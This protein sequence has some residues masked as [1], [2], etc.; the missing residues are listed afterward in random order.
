MTDHQ[1]AAETAEVSGARPDSA[2]THETAAQPVS[3]QTVEAVVRAQLS[4]ALGGKRGM[5]EA[6][7][8]TLTFTVAYMASQELRLSLV[9]SVGVAVVLAVIRLIQRTS[10]QFVVNSLFGIGIAAVFALRSGDAE[11]FALPGII[12]NA[13]YAAVLTLTVLIRW[14]AIGL[15]IGAVTGDPTGWRD[16]PAVVRL[17]SRLTWLLVLPC[18]VRVAVQLPLWAA[19]SYGVANTFAFLGIAKIAM[20]WPL[21]VAA[22]AA[23]VWLLARGRTPMADEAAG[24]EAA[25]RP[26]TA[27]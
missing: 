23:M 15:L 3:E 5:V 2:A 1:R 18:V 17:S 9:L 13:V 10:V 12:Y 24:T 26:R 25:A 27:E 7:I 4:K 16:N 8:P 6:A 22:L 20:G 21:Q 11:D 19:E 14:P